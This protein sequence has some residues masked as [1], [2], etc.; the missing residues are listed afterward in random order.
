MKK[1][2]PKTLLSAR[3]E[4]SFKEQF[5]Q[6]AAQCEMNVSSYTEYCLR[7]FNSVSHDLQISNENNLIL[8]KEIDSLTAKYRDLSLENQEISEDNKQLNTNLHS[9]SKEFDKLTKRI[10][11]LNELLNLSSLSIEEKDTEINS[12][13]ANL[14]AFRQFNNDKKTRIENLG[15]E[16]DVLKSRNNDLAECNESLIHQYE[17]CLDENAQ[18][19]S[20]IAK[21]LPYNLNPEEREKTINSLEELQ[22]FYKDRSQHE[23]LPLAL[24][25]I[26]ENENRWVH[27][28]DI[29]DFIKKHPQYLMPQ[30]IQD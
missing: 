10:G 7:E 22:R 8:Q 28:Y 24:G 4:E 6:E 18:L 17:Q 14:K 1:N 5:A 16:V 19:R 2:R 13:Q 15:S 20:E 27:M 25:T 11:H 12:L 26:L 23:L 9:L 30:T 29:A 21:R 3:V